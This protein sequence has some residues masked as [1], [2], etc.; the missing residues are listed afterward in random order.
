MLHAPSDVILDDGNAYHP[1]IFFIKKDRFFIIDEM[2]QIV[3]GAPDLVVEILSKSTAVYDKGIKK[4]TCEKYGVREYWL[5][6]P[7]K[8]SIEVYGL[9]EERFRL[10]AYFEE[11]GIL[12][13][14]VLEDFEMDI[15]KIFSDATSSKNEG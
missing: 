4:D 8:K 3:K 1:D 14:S 2:E 7:Q 15:A 6:D 9:K 5:V 12:K 10:T 11:S 13:S